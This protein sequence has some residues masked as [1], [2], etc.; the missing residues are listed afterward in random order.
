[1]TDSTGRENRA[2][3][4]KDAER[5]F[6]DELADTGARFAPR[7]A[8]EY[9]A[10]F[11]ALGIGRDLTGMRV[12]E[13]GCA[14]GDFGILLAGRGAEVTGVDLS[15]GMIEL[16]SRLN[17]SVPGYSARAGDLEDPG[18]FGEGAFDAVACFNVLHHFP[19]IGAVVANFARWLSPDGAVWAEEP[20]GS[21]PVNRL[22]KALR[23][24]VK[25]VS[26]GTLHRRKL[27]SLNEERDYTMAEY[28]ALFAA[29]G[30]VCERETSLTVA[31]DAAE[32][33]RGLDAAISL[34]K[35]SLYAATGRVFSDPM[36][37]GQ[38]LAFVMRRGG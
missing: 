3:Q 25:L 31:D 17:A 36:A 21:N 15:E 29:H 6:F 30:F 24:A 32:S 26:P 23:G 19:D 18:L 1:M 4:N 10:V 14:T 34:V 20:N 12:L 8:G 37:R 9:E 35:R 22:S 13:A 33:K 16:N 5:A 11:N 2:R 38:Y 27:S 7:P 28:R